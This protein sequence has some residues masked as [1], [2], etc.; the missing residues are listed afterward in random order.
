MYHR[1]E[2]TLRKDVV[3]IVLAWQNNTAGHT[4]LEQRWIGLATT[5]DDMLQYRPSSSAFAPYC[6]LCWISAKFGYLRTRIVN[7]LTMM[8]LRIH[9]HASESTSEQ[10]LGPLRILKFFS[11]CRTEEQ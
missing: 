7:S 1:R 6:H 4:L 5:C 2:Y 3:V 9:L 8:N 11:I 10:I